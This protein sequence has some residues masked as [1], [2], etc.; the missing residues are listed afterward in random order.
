MGSD[1]ARGIE[2]QAPELIEEGA[3]AGALR[4]VEGRDRLAQL[5]QEQRGALVA[6]GA[7][8]GHAGLELIELGR[9]PQVLS[10]RDR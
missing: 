7:L 6:V 3:G 5:Q 4:H 10:R 2:A 1:A 8:L 9:G